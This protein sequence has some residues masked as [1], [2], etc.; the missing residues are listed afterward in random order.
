MDDKKVIKRSIYALEIWNTVNPKYFNLVV[1]INNEGKLQLCATGS[2]TP[3][4]L[5]T[6]V[7]KGKVPKG[8]KVFDYDN[9][10][11]YNND[12]LIIT[13]PKYFDFKK[14][15][16]IMYIGAESIQYGKKTFGGLRF[17]VT[18]KKIG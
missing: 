3:G 5:P 1:K 13:F 17:Y 12:K 10:L 9:G 16:Y 14:G 8:V 11:S 7:Q 4:R 15:E 2:L 6:G 18:N